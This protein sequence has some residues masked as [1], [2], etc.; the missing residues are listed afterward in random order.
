MPL[1]SGFGI[2]SPLATQVTGQPYFKAEALREAL[3]AVDVDVV[4]FHNISLIGGPGVLH[5]GRKAVRLMTAHEHW[6]IC[7]MHLLWKYGKKPCDGPECVRCSIAGGG[8]RRP[9]GRPTRSTEASSSST[10]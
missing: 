10:P 7:P 5:Y 8:R 6:L 9:G 2:L 3:D 4:H 1:E